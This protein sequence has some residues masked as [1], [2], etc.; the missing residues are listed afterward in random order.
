[1]TKKNPLQKAPSNSIPRRRALTVIAG[2][3]AGLGSL[4]RPGAVLGNPPIRYVWRGTAMGAEASVILYHPDRNE[5][6]R[7]VRQSILE[8]ERLESEFSLYRTESAL[9]R[10]NRDGFL[11]APSLDMVRL[12]S[13]CR[14]FGDISKGSFDVTVQPLWRLYADHFAAHPDDV[15]GPPRT[16]VIAARARVNYRRMDVQTGRIVLKDG[17][18]ITLN[19]IAQGYITDRVADLLRS[20]GWS[21]VL[22]NLGETRALDGR[23]GGAPWT[24]ALDGILDS[25]SGRPLTVPLDDRAMATSAGAGTRFDSSGSHHHLFDPASGRSPCHYRAVTVTAPDATT[26]DALSTA[27]F[28]APRARA[29][30][31]LAL[32]GRSGGVA[33]WLTDTSGKTEFLRD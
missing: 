2:F 30:H 3:G 4:L 25:D 23:A 32:A 16:P 18:E 9:C 7:A 15:T 28:A 24:V 6:E 22:I 29:A 26:A 33:A 19:G 8:I 14:R 20:R 10:L 27:I 12:L 31:M 21:N 1:M 13:E 17:A 5:A 11:D